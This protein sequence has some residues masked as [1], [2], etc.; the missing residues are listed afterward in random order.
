ML[1]RCFILSQSSPHVFLPEYLLPHTRLGPPAHDTHEI[2]APKEIQL[3]NF[4]IIYSTQ[5][6]AILGL[7]SRDRD[8]YKLIV[9]L[10][11]ETETETLL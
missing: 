5:G 7:E 9:S 11:V 6:L 8:Q 3:C 2:K 1:L 10:V 4:G